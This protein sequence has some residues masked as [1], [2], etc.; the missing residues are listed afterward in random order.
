M[1]SA[2]P[3]R[4]PAE[5]ASES[6]GGINALNGAR[7]AGSGVARARTGAVEAAASKALDRGAGRRHDGSSVA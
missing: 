4:S 6:G 2:S 7:G 1:S 3:R 5:T